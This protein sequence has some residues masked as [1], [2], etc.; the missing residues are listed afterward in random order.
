MRQNPIVYPPGGRFGPRLQQDIQLVL[1][2][3]G[4]MDVS[5][6]GE[7]HNAQSG[8]VV[9]LKPDHACRARC[10]ASWSSFFNSNAWFHLFEI[11]TWEEM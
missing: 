5:I 4:Q 10:Q 6:D 11:S 9:I 8:N 7:L 2:H 1:L 3:T